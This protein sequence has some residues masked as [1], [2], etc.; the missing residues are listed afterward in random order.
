MTAFAREERQIPEGYACWEIRS[1]N[2]RYQ[3]INARLPEELRSLEGAVRKHVGKRVQRGKIECSLRFQAGRGTG[4]QFK[5]NLSLAEQLLAAAGQ[6]GKLRGA[7]AQLKAIDILRW[8]GVLEPSAIDLEELSST[9]LLLLDDALTQIVAHREREGAQIAAFI[10]QRCTAIAEEISRVRRQLPGI[11]ASQREKLR[12]RLAE[13]MEKLDPDRLEQEM[14]ILA[15]KVDVEEEL[16]R[17]ETHLVEIRRVLSESKPG[18][19]RLDFL[20]QELNREANTMG[21]KSIHSVTTQASLNV[22]VLIEQ[23]R[24]QIQNVE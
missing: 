1:V 4:S 18:G 14:V 13:F 12:T 7:S 6:V 15:Q 20:M 11:L 23:M 3:E 21:A 5:V 24:E 2:H 16:D 17:L 8:P 10:E 9:L 22:K 19:R